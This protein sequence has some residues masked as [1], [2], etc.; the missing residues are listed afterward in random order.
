MLIFVT[1][2]MRYQ[3]FERLVEKMDEIAGKICEK[4]LMQI[5]NTQYKPKNAKYFRFKDYA[6]IKEI[7]YGL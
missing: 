7:Y 3:G 5:G 4:V 6:E 2:G 1:V